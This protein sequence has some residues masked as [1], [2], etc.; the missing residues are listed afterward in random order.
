M[1]WGDR[2]VKLYQTSTWHE[3]REFNER[4]H[5]RG[6]GWGWWGGGGGGHVPRLNF[7]ASYVAV[8]EHSRVAR[9]NFINNFF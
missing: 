5:V 3:Y 7:T 2:D 1:C 4:G 9:R 6:E 8:S